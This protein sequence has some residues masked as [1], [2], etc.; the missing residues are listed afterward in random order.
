MNA[1]CERMRHTQSVDRA[2]KAFSKA[3]LKNQ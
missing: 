3:F 2:S 1:D